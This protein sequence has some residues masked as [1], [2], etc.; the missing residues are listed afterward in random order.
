MTDDIEKVD[1]VSEP[2]DAD[3]SAELIDTD[4]TDALPKSVVSKIVARERQ[5]AEEKAYK[6]GRDEALMELQNQEAQPVEAQEQQAVA[7]PTP[8]VTG[9]QPILAKHP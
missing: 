5:K 9:K 6:K 8:I 2:V 1:A 3:I 7:A 4:S